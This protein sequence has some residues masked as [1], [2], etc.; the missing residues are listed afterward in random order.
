MLQTYPF[1]QPMMI[2]KENNTTMQIVRYIL[3]RLK[4]ND[5]FAKEKAVE[6]FPQP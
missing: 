2:L 6:N 3:C 5:S 1:Y 4:S